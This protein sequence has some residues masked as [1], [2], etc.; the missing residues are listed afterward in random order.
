MSNYNNRYQVSRRNYGNSYNAPYQQKQQY[1]RQTKKRTGA[2]AGVYVNQDGEQK[3]YVRG[4]NA[5]KIHGIITVFCTPYK[6]TDEHKSKSGRVCQNWMAKVQI[7]KQKPYTTS[8]LYYP[9]S[10]KV[11]VTDLGFVINPN[12]RNGGYCGSFSNK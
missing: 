1:Q 7:G 3:Q 9:D 10:R 6:N 11:V 5:S 12:A 4:W 8:C 2:S